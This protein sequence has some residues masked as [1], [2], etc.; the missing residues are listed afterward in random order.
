V[1]DALPKLRGAKW[2]AIGRLDYNT[3]GLMIFTTSGE[4]ANNLM[5]P[6]F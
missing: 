3:D 1:F 5:H 6:R 2:I 4:L